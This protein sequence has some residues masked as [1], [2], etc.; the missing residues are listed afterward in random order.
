MCFLALLNPSLIKQVS[1]KVKRHLCCR[2]KNNDKDE[3]NKKLK[4]LLELEEHIDT[5]LVKVLN[6]IHKFK[7]QLHSY[8]KQNR[9]YWSS[10]DN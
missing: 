5:E 6:D 9:T 7:N 10:Y 3:N 1:L 4:E 8:K 2:S